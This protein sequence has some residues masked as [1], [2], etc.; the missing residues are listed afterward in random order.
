MTLGKKIYTLRKAHQMSQECLAEA[1]GVSRQ[2]VSKWETGQAY[3]STEKL[4]RI[5]QVFEVSVDELADASTKVALLDDVQAELTGMRQKANGLKYFIVA[6]LVIFVGTFAAALY[7]RFN[8]Y[9]D[10]VVLLW[11]CLAAGAVLLAFLP[12]WVM[13]L[14][15][16][17]KDC[18]R[19]GIKPTF[20][21]LISCSI[22]GLVYYILQRDT[23]AQKTK[24]EA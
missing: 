16:V 5:A 17:Y 22:V 3:P 8:G 12:I 1:T 10:R 19:R 23:L 7:T 24:K 4:I 13:I 14:H 21:V 20:Y 11:V 9:G 2:A 18:K 15:Y 6:M